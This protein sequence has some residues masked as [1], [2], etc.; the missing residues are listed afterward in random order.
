M[1]EDVECPTGS[2]EDRKFTN[3]KDNSII[4]CLE[5][6]IAQSFKNINGSKITKY[7]T[8]VR[9]YGNISSSL[10]IG[11]A[12]RTQ[13]ENYPWDDREW[14]VSGAIAGNTIPEG[15]DTL[16]YHDIS[17]NP[18]EY[19]KFTELY[20]ILASV[21]PYADN[22]FFTVP[23]CEGNQFSGGFLHHN[24]EYPTGNWIREIDQDFWFFT[25]TKE[26][27]T[28]EVT[29]HPCQTASEYGAFCNG[30]F[31]N[32]FQYGEKIYAYGLYEKQ[33]G[34][35]FHG[36]KLS[37]K[38]YH[39]STKIK[40]NSTVVD[41]HGSQT[42]YRCSTTPSSSGTGYIDFYYKDKFIKRTNT[43]TV[44]GGNGGGVTLIEALTTDSAGAGNEC[45]HN[46]EKTT[47]QIGEK[48][49]WYAEWEK[50]GDVYGDKVGYKWYHNDSLFRENSDTIDNHGTGQCYYGYTG[51]LTTPGTGYI[52]FYYN[53]KYSGVTK[54]YTLEG[55]GE[56]N[57]SILSSSVFYEGPYA[58]N[59]QQSLADIN[60]KNIGDAEGKI[61]VKLY[62]YPG[63][64]NENYL[65]G[66]ATDNVSPNET[67]TEYL[68][69]I[70]PSIPGSW[71]LGIK[72][73][74]E[75]E[76]EPSWGS[77][78]TRRWG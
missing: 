60:I 59:T 54:T 23:Y 43:Y 62:E 76:A 35:D 45:V 64:D 52:K 30:T 29:C 51:K 42:C 67:Y 31:K 32:T 16:L 2:S 58:P 17:S 73:F 77:Y 69:H 1:S 68:A 39:N 34:E 78:N 49:Y 41:G 71:P 9:R 50:D 8:W 21:E 65:F 63:T 44:E 40:E 12:T 74:G 28:D 6:Q 72:V 3:Q 11:L 4:V 70:I 57:A 19:P 7:G 53:D 47:F 48:I 25:C 14:L 26:G 37:Y 13:I 56:I 27:T 15:K 55:A 5:Q 20:L 38:W 66:V 75:T 18:V 61:T 46:P 10:Y 33:P 22:K 24:L 36:E